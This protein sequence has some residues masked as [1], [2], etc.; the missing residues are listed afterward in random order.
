MGSGKSSLGRRLAAE[1]GWKFLDTDSEIERLAGMKIPEIFEIKG[2]EWFRGLE[3]Q[4]IDGLSGMEGGTVVALGGGAVCREGV[5]E[6][7]NG[8]GMSIYLKMPPEM[9]VAR[10]DSGGRDKRPKI[11]GMNDEQ[12]LA[13][14]NNL[15]PER[16]IYY[17]KATFALD[18]GA[19][20]DAQIV[21]LLMRTVE[22]K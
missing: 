9:L 8:L 13:Y 10:I 19:M 11:R 18:C 20:G 3:K 6:K 12:L 5:M 2:E 22:S 15:L 1:A 7:L 16:E 14:I 17:N 4:V 21:E